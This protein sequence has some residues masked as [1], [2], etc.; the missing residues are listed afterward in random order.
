ML[1]KARVPACAEKQEGGSRP[2][3]WCV[4]WTSQHLIH[5]MVVGWRSSL[6]ACHCLGER[7]LP[8]TQRS[9]HC[10]GLQRQERLHQMVQLLARSR[11]RK[12]R[13]YPELVHLR[14]R[15]RLVVLAGEVAGRWS[16]ETLRFIGLLARGRAR[17]EIK[18]M[19]RRVEQAWRLRWWTMFSC[20]AARA[21]AASWLGVSCDHS[22]AG[23][24]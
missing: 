17:N 12:E 1:W 6:M 13:T 20:D 11:R 10:D 8:W 19:R 16:E 7:S 3:T 15:T 22:Y 4:T 21:F 24:G 5:V 9:L 14:A 18:L 23:L 2:T